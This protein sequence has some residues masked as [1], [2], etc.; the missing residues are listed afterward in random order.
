MSLQ[1]AGTDLG[2]TE[3]T[4]V[5]QCIT[6]RYIAEKTNGTLVKMTANLN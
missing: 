5:L 4:L 6:V 3:D 1:L 2:F